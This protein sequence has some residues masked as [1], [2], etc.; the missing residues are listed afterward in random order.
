MFTRGICCDFCFSAV[1]SGVF[2]RDGEK[3]LS[4]SRDCTVKVWDIEREE[5]KV[6]LEGHNQYD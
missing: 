1:D 6:T 5:C 4:G 2:S 3:A